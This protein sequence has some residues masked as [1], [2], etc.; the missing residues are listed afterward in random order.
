MKL[1]LTT[2][3]LCVLLV[4]VIAG[5]SSCSGELRYFTARLDNR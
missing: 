4:A 1:R 3:P 2:V 5:C